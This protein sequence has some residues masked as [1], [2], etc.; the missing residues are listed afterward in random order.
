MSL[1]RAVVTAAL[2]VGVSLFL[3]AV[4][5]MRG[6]DDTGVTRVEDGRPLVALTFDDGPNGAYTLEIA[7]ALERRGGRGTFFV[8][9]APMAAQRKVALR[10]VERGHLLAN[11]SQTHERASNS[12]VL[13]RTLGHAQASIGAVTGQCPAYFRPPFGQE[14]PFTKAAVRR[15]G[16]Q[17]VLWDVEVGD[18]AETDP[19]RLAG[20]V[21]ERARAGSIVLLH[22]GADGRPGTDRSTVVRALPAILDG[23]E[24]RGLRA[25]TVAELLGGTGYLPRC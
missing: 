16:M 22:D 11:H 10:L 24:A 25:V 15:A 2:L 6:W 18:W 7:E 4:W 9:G 8:V 12:N 1:R 17:T 5:A 13:Y 19:S 20:R 21:L 3:G 14:T 23:L